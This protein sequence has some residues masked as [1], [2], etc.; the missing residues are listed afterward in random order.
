MIRIRIFAT[1]STYEVM[2]W[3]GN[4][5]IAELSVNVKSYDACGRVRQFVSNFK[6][7]E[8]EDDLGIIHV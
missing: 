3:N 6:N 5:C 4:K 8:L 2:V 7:Y 1:F